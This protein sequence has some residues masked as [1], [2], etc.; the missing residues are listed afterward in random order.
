MDFEIQGFRFSLTVD[1]IKQIIGLISDNIHKDK[2]HLCLLLHL[3]NAVILGWYNAITKVFAPQLAIK[4]GAENRTLTYEEVSSLVQ[5]T[6]Q[7][8]FEPLVTNIIKL[9]KQAMNHYHDKGEQHLVEQ[10]SNISSWL[11][12]F[13]ETAIKQKGSWLEDALREDRSDRWNV[14]PVNI[15]LWESDLE[16]QRGVVRELTGSIETS[17]RCE[18][19]MV[20]ELLTELRQSR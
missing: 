17:L 9:L 16:Y 15:F 7:R 3:T 6:Q 11:T 18:R 20:G 2:K 5:F 19:E 12:A 4:V 14:T 13:S 10:I 1:E 8:E